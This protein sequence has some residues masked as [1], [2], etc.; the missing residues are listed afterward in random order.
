MDQTEPSFSLDAVVQRRQHALRP[1]RCFHPGPS[2]D[3]RFW[4]LSSRR[5]HLRS[6]CLHRCQLPASTSLPPVPRLGF[7][8]RACRSGRPDPRY[9]EGSDSRQRPPHQRV[10]PLQFAYLPRVPSPTTRCA[11]SSL[12]P[13]LQRDRFLPGFAVNEQA[14]RYTPPKRVRFTT[15]RRF[16]SSCSPP[17]LTATQLLSTSGSMAHPGADSHRADTRPSWAHSPRR[18][19]GPS[20]FYPN[21]ELRLHHRKDAGPRPSPG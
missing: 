1:H 16:V 9:H 14:R 8:L 7:A 18:R 5:R 17:R 19:P 11:R 13:P 20:D 10:S 2:L 3:P 6:S 4:P 12:W 21:A 15:D